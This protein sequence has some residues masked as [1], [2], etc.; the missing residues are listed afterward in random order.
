MSTA[1]QVKPLIGQPREYTGAKVVSIDLYRS[2]ARGQVDL[3]TLEE[4]VS[5]LR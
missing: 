4:R 5:Y 1:A 3:F 2:G